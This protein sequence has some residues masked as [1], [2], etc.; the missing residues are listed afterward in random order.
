MA[1]KNVHSRNPKPFDKVQVLLYLERRVHSSL[2]EETSL[3]KMTM[4]E[5]VTEALE[6]RVW[7]IRDAPKE[8]S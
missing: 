2:K 5:I 6:N 1:R 3:R 8:A 4:G 7:V